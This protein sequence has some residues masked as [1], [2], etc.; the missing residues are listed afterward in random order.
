[1]DTVSK[2]SISVQTRLF[3]LIVIFTWVLTAA[4]FAMQYAREKE[5]KVQLLDTRLQAV[6]N[7]VLEVLDDSVTSTAVLARLDHPD[8]VRLSLIDINGRVLY[9]NT[10]HEIS[11][12]HSDRPEIRAA[13]TN[14]HGYTVRRLSSTID[15]EYFYSAT[16]G[17]SIIVRTALPYNHS[18]ASMLQADPEE[19]IFVIVIAII[20]T[21]IAWFAARR[22]S[23]GVKRLRDFANAAEFGDI[24]KFD[25][26]QF[27]SDELGEIS[28]HIVNLY[29]IQQETA[30]QRD[31]SLREA[32]REQ[33]DKDRLKR[34]LTNNI[35][36]EIKTPV[37]VIQASLETLSNNDAQLDADTRKSL[38]DKAYANSQRLGSLLGDLT[39]ITRINEAPQQITRVNV[40]VVP[41]IRQVADDM[42][43]MPPE[44]Q[45]RIHLDLPDKI[46]VAGNASLLDSIFRNL[47]VNAF[48]YSGGRDLYVT[49]DAEK[50]DSYHFVV[51]DNGVGVPPEH[52]PHIF[53]RF[54][55]I[56]AGRSRAMGGT[57]L[58]LAIVKNAVSFHGGTVKAC[59]REGGGLQIEFNL[60][61]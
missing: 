61:K 1:M 33:R 30:E 43:V 45:M 2:P 21:I 51:A 9:D 26:T 10:G 22:I 49:M 17:D 4:F 24:T 52:L 13:M 59:T 32:M 18:L 14:G 47:M 36:H 11:A 28:T 16:R 5:Y 55:R 31:Q 37:Q 41:I 39:T 38:I 6:N 27:T 12:N 3:L 46:I 53:E 57:G 60:N 42:K 40:D 25:T 20:M 50:S 23:K 7:N 8:S 29:K 48:N 15:H 56:D 35:S 54:Y 19:S 58:G 44:R 34:Q